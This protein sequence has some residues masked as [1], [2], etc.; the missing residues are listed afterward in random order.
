M[1]QQIQLRNGTAAQWTSANPILAAG[2]LGV[3]TDTLMF[4]VGNGVTH[5]TSLTYA[6]SVSSSFATNALSASLAISAS[7]APTGVSTT[8]ISASWAS[9]SLSASFALTASYVSGS[10]G[11]W[12]AIKGTISNQTDLQNQLNVLFSLAMIGV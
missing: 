8:A 11:A 6:T 1:A 2:E 10:G 4:K 9:Q 5:W 3:E 7:W 12:G